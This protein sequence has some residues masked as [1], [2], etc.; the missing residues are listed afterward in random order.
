MTIKEKC[1]LL[2]CMICLTYLPDSEGMFYAL[3]EVALF[4]SALVFYS[5]SKS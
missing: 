5:D 1:G 2:L 4:I 3:L